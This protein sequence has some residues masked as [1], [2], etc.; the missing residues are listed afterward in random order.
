MKQT[1][2]IMAIGGMAAAL[3]LASVNAAKALEVHLGDGASLDALDAPQLQLA[4]AGSDP[5]SEPS[6]SR[7]LRLT[8]DAGATA[9]VANPDHKAV[10]TYVERGRIKRN[11]NPFSPGQFVDLNKHGAVSFFNDSRTVSVVVLIANSASAQ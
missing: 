1:L 7:T 11:G 9:I 6:P 3:F 10:I 4:D 2:R 5:D 8:L